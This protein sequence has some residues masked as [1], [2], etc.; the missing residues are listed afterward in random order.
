[1]PSRAIMA[2]P[3]VATLVVRRIIRATPERLF[4]A[5]TEP[6]QLVHWWGP[7]G[8]SCPVAEVDLRPGGRYRIANRFADGTLVWIAGVFEVVEPPRRLI[9]T[10]QLESA[11]A[12]SV[13]TLPERV[14]VCF[15]AR[16]SA[17][18][19][20]VTHER[21]ASAAARTS[22]ELGWSGCLDGLAR[23]AERL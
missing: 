23:Y 13:P 6:Q 20:I 22:H 18:E 2:E 3:P 19:V 7:E 17:T 11:A 21:I 12:A 5:W 10:W 9:Y 4:A 1:M 16:D 14:S 15:E 8:V